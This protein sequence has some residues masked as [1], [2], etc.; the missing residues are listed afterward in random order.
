[1][2]R[3]K[4]Y[5]QR[6]DRRQRRPAA[7]HP[8]LHGLLLHAS[9]GPVAPLCL[10][11]SSEQLPTAFPPPLHGLLLHASLGP[12]APLC[13]PHSSAQ[14]PTAFHP[15]LHGLLLHASLGPVAPLVIERVIIPQKKQDP[16]PHVGIRYICVLKQE[17]PCLHWNGHDEQPLARGS[18]RPKSPKQ[19]DTLPDQADW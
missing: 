19:P 14:L 11:H 6:R 10:P 12:V 17:H 18:S 1:M 4:G 15:P 16:L 9:L 3:R 2:E 7:F 5:K 13:L 8:P